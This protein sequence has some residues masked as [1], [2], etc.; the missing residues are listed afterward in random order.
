MKY[1]F[2]KQQTQIAKGMAILLMLI[3]HLFFYPSDLYV[4]LVKMGGQD[5][6]SYISSFG[7]ICVAMFLFLSGYGITIS[8]VKKET[9]Y[10]KS[11]IS[12]VINLMINY[13][14]VFLLFV[15]IGFFVTER[16]FDSSEFVSNLFL[17]SILIIVR[18]GF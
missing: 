12:R 1:K 7:K 10:K 13:W 2:T 11:V 14:I 15:P 18:G 9:S 5:I 17:I 4:S 8:S 16:N 6:E 3:H